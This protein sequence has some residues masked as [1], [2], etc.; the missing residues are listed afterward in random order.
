MKKFIA[1]GAM[2]MGSIVSAQ[3]SAVKTVESVN[4]DRYVGKWHEIAKFPNRFQKNCAG[5]VSAEYHKLEDGRIS[6]INRCMKLDGIDQQVAG[7]AKVVEASGNA[8]LKVRFAPAWLSW[9]PMVWG[10]YWVIALAPDYSY[11][12]V[13]EPK[14][15]YLWVLSRTPTMLEEKYREAV[16]QAEKQGFDV[17]KL[18]RT[19]Q[20]I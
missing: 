5:N 12:V 9:L 13:G 17:K 11:V 2:L 3:P 8:K 1:I 18:E 4:L 20:G 7:V 16:K 15:E 6:V 19:K 14:R 10:D